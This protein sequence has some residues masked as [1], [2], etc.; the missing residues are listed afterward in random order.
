MLLKSL[1]I[2]YFQ[3]F[4]FQLRTSC[5]FSQY[6]FSCNA[7]TKKINDNEFLEGSSSVDGPN[8]VDCGSKYI[9]YF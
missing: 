3:E 8:M 7:R 1:N 4:E 6:K 9:A 2:S 5:D